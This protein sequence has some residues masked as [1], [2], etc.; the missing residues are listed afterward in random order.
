M[1]E[2]VIGSIAGLLTI[3]CCIPQ[4]IKMLKTKSMKDFSWWY[5]IMLCSGIALW[6]L[7]GLY[8]NDNV[9]IG[10]NISLWVLVLLML[11]GKWL[12]GKTPIN[13]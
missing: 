3:L 7:Y 9:I 8:K 13:H 10:T 5:L 11:F 4:I 1:I 2:T 6:I 12:Y